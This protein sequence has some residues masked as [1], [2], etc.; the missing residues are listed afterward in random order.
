MTP[1]TFR[2]RQ[3]GTALIVG[4]V[5]LVV[6][7]TLAVAGM[8]TSTL[9]LVM[10]GNSQYQQDAFQAAEAGLERA[11]GGA[12]LVLEDQVAAH[13]LPGT[14]DAAQTVVTWVDAT[15][16]LRGGTSLGA[17]FAAH[18]FDITSVGTANRGASATHNQGFYI[19]G[20]DGS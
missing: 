3:N 19:V 9:E 18:H 16:N 14:D 1:M 5:L 10:A 2:H 13:D 15:P 8:Q 6:L 12:Q 7:T 4:M 20:P 11:M 17:G